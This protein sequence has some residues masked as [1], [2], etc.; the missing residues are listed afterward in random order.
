[1]YR[2]TVLVGLT[3]S[4]Y[5]ITAVIGA[6]GMGEVYRATDTRLGREVALKVLPEALATDADRIAR[7]QREAQVLAS[8]N[9]SNIA[10]VYGIEDGALVMELVEGKTLAAR[11]AQGPIPVDE[12]LPIARQIAEAVEAAHDRGI[13]HRD[14]KPANVKIT[15]EGTVKVLDF[16]LAKTA[17]DSVTPVDPSNSPT[18]TTPATQAGMIMGTAA[19]MAPEQARGHVV[20][21]RADIWSF[22]AVLF[23]M[24]SGRQAFA[25][26]TT[27]DILASVL[28]LDPDWNALPISTPAS[29]V[30]LLR[31]CLTKDRK[32]RLQAIGEARIAIDEA[33]SSDVGPGLAPA[34]ASDTQGPP[35][36]T[37]RRAR[38]LP[39]IT[40]VCAALIAGIAGWWASARRNPPSLDWSAQML[41][42]PSIAMGPRISPDGHT[43]AFQAMVDALTQVAVMDVESGDWTVLT[44]DRSHG[45]V[46]ELN[47]SP[48][49][50]QIYFDRYLAA[51]HGIYTVSRFGG[52][53]H[54][55]LEDAKGPEVLPDGSLL[56]ERFNHDRNLQLYRFWPE[57]GRVE[58]LDAVFLQV[59]DI[60]TCVRPFHDGKEAVF[61][62][63]RLE[64]L[65]TDPSPHLYV[66]DLTSKQTRR[67]AAEIDFRRTSEFKLFPIAVPID[68]QSVL[69]EVEA[70]DLHRVIS[71]PRRGT[72]PIRT[73]FSLTLEPGLMDVD[74]DGDIYLDQMD[75]PMEVLRSSP[76]GGEPEVL[77]GPD[78]TSM[79]QYLTTR[80][81]DGRAVFESLLARRS[82]LL[83]AKPGTEA[84][85]F[86]ET[87]EETSLPACQVGKDKIAFLLG[88]PGKAV[89][90]LAS[91]SDGRILARLSGLPTGITD[92]AAS[93]DGTTLY[94]VASGTVSAVS[95]RGGPPR[96]IVPG[97]GVAADPDGEH[98]I[99]QLI[100]QEGVRLVR[101]PASGGDEQPIPVKADL[102][103]AP[104]VLS[105]N[106]I[107]KD[108]RLVL[109]VTTPDSWFYGMGVL[110]P[111][112]GKL[113]RIP[114][115]FSG[116]TLGPGW[117]DDGRVFV[118]GWPL[119]ASLW[120]FH[121]ASER[122]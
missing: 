103:L 32:Q 8:V 33:L 63:E 16:G 74:K 106:A 9:H 113:E 56:F 96:R 47:W 71:I 100:G 60:A 46:T 17:G 65:G 93:P 119:K 66:V 30:R 15:P 115:I 121:P 116:D 78:S 43:L 120:R 82:R 52:D 89:V 98:L 1:M 22:G 122:Q 27:S 110:D 80:L 39:W 24:L 62:G 3:L 4:H 6:G 105:P 12:A 35:R 59:S 21:K 40:A 20:D 81:P 13:I 108:G 99:V 26:Q 112:S 92:L 48:D 94:Y 49:G 50:S 11:I 72:G 95:V 87:K 73:L 57:S 104:V 64:Q 7:F 23:E 118:S 114:L 45:Y 28:K 79:G 88:P 58:A 5:R 31:R 102:L 25:G 85:P 18:M 69:V 101:V 53:E 75:R 36:G 55:I 54:L 41:G 51:P 86:V 38:A 97:D 19:Y 61:F 29:I 83:A 44:K 76:A 2:G 77:A 111:R 107:G 37:A 109:S 90:A 70:G 10:T 84:A 91:A 42:G 117:L 67:L 34:A 68:D 14:L